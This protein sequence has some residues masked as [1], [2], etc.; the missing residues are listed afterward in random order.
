[1]LG[2]KVLNEAIALSNGLG[3]KEKYVI[4]VTMNDEYVIICIRDNF[5]FP[6]VHMNLV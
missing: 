5:V 6:A 1:M 4:A 2:I 3:F